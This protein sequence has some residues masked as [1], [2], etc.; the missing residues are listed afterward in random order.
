MKGLCKD[1]LVIWRSGNL[2]TVSISG[3]ENREHDDEAGYVEG[4]YVQVWFVPES[5]RQPI[6]RALALR[7]GRMRTRTRQTGLDWTGQV[8]RKYI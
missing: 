1:E 2:A 6:Y 4:V 5:N 7:A 8:C 3:V